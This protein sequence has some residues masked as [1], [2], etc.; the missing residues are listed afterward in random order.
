MVGC[1]D[2][3][4]G[5]CGVGHIAAHGSDWGSGRVGGLL[6]WWIRADL[7]VGRSWR[8]W[9]A[10]T[11]AGLLEESLRLSRSLSLL[12]PGKRRLGAPGKTGVRGEGEKG[13][14]GQQGRNTSATE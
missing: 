13:G 2:E 3:G 8:W 12:L 14:R 5:R 11:S 9:V 10:W 1:G 7:V 4:D 6:F